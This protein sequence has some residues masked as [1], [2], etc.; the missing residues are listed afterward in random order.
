[1]QDLTRYMT[2][3]LAWRRECITVLAKDA[4]KHVPYEDTKGRARIRSYL[5]V[6]GHHAILKARQLGSSTEILLGALHRS[7]FRPGSRIALVAHTADA[8]KALLRHLYALYASQPNHVKA[9]FA[10]ASK[11]AYR[12]EFDNGS[13]IQANTAYSESWRSQTY[14]YLHLSEAAHWTDFNDTIKSLL[15]TA[16][17]NAIVVYETT[18]KGP[19]EFHQA[20]RDTALRWNRIFLPWFDHPEYQ[21]ATI[22]LGEWTDS[23]LAYRDSL[24]VTLTDEQ[25][26]WFRITLATKCG[27]NIDTFRQE[28]PSDPDSCFLLSGRKFFPFLFQNIEC[29]AHQE[30]V[31][32]FSKPQ[33]YH[34]YAVGVD[35]ASGSPTGDFTTLTI[36]DITDPAHSFIALRYRARLA[37]NQWA[38]AAAKLIRPYGPHPAGDGARAVLVES[39]HVGVAIAET[40]RKNGVNTL[41]KDG[42][43]VWSTTAQSRPRLLDH[44][45]AA[46]NKRTL[47]VN[48][49]LTAQECNAFAYNDKGKPEATSGNHD[50]LVFSLAL[51]VQAGKYV[52]SC[53][54][55]V[56]ANP[57]SQ[58]AVHDAIA[59]EMR[60]FKQHGSRAFQTD[61]K[62]SWPGI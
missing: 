60:R 15:Q 37:P 58:H 39:N 44:L 35:G 7:Q 9:Q 12:I 21:T 3:S 1:M 5:R 61:D 10:I 17:P 50:D 54:P 62:E 45:H 6:P 23:E 4:G 57:A 24:P 36:L 42:K 59:D 34:R 2:D 25:C 33:P 8:A 32:L 48:D 46:I 29:P 47:D 31:A 30:T 40:L 28:Y 11:A 14:D 19:N 52:A 26:N 18:P 22:P 55:P 13:F 49:P 43:L 16:A 53:A 38:E 51:A 56:Q 27:G 20:W 41:M